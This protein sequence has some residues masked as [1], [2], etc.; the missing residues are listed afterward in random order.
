LR[1]IHEVEIERPQFETVGSIA[2][3]LGE[4]GAGDVLDHPEVSVEVVAFDLVSG[5][6]SAPQEA[7]R[8]LRIKWLYLCGPSKR[9]AAGHSGSAQGYG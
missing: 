1:P 6:C 7:V 4:N 9:I 2:R 3:A 5:S 8:K